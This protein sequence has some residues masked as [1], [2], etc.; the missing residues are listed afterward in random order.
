MSDHIP[1]P[2]PANSTAP[3]TASAVVEP[4]LPAPAGKNTIGL[5]ALIFAGVAVLTAVIP[6]AAGSTWLFA[7]PAIVLGIISL[8]KKRAPKWYGLVAV[9]AAPI[10]WLIAIVVATVFV[11]SSLTSSIN[12]ALSEQ[13][14][15]PAAEAP[16]AEP[17]A[18]AEE[19][20]PANTE[21]TIGQTLTNNDGVAVTFTSVACGIATA[22]PEYFTENAKGQFCEVKYSVQNGGSEQITLL[23]SDVTGELGGSTYESS[24]S[25]SSFGGDMFTT[26]VNPGLGTDAVVYIDIPADKALEYIV[27]KPAWGLFTDEIRVKVG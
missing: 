8:V 26:N 9:I 11:A 25:L 19:P 16:Q 2:P 24:S 17:S 3:S 4:P 13:G 7:I 23:A 5:V 12:D 20:A 22:G 27:F 10:A 15:T 1:G 21:A 14:G 18:A 6:A